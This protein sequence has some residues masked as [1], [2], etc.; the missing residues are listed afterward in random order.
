MLPQLVSAVFWLAVLALAW[1]M[2]NHPELTISLYEYGFGY[3]PDEHNAAGQQ[4]FQDIMQVTV[5]CGF[6]SSSHFCKAYRSLFGH[7][8]SEERRGKVGESEAR[9][10]A[11]RKR[12]VPLK[13][14]A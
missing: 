14:A 6:Q 8:P 10:R 11:S 7:A 3:K 2:S 12:V 1:G 13:R 4:Q 9:T 5:A